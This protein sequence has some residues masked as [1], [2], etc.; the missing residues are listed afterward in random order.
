MKEFA[1]RPGSLPPPKT[2]KVVNEE[3]PPRVPSD[4]AR[5]SV[6]A[7]PLRVL[8]AQPEGTVELAPELSVTFSDA[9]V[10][11][12]AQDEAAATKVVTLAPELPGEPWSQSLILATIDRALAS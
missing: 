1:L 8:R 9:M 11:V 7:G 12:T 5:P 10:A 2:G 6:E 3:F 4:V